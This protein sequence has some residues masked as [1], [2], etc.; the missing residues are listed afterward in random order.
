MPNTTTATWPTLTA[1]QV[2]RASDVEGKFDWSEHHLWPHSAGT[3]V[4]NAYDLGD[5]T[6]AY[7]RTAWLYSL[8]ATTSAQGIAIGTTTVANNSN[9]SFE[10][11][12]PRT[13]LIP[14]F[15]S[16][17]ESAFT[18]IN[19]MVGYNST[20]NKFRVYQNGGWVDMVGQPIGIVAMAQTST[21]DS[22]TSTVVSYTG[23]G[24]VRGIIL[25]QGVA[26]GN[27]GS[28]YVIVD[29]VT[30]TLHLPGTASAYG[31]TQTHDTTTGF[32]WTTAGAT[33][34]ALDLYFRTNFSV[35][36]HGPA[37]PAQTQTVFVIYERA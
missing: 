5:S 33:A 24:R 20:T 1:G 26:P 4:S 13:M 15:T 25:S 16:A 8:N 23:A 3:R 35:Q 34:T 31:L 9:V 6:T 29:S 28:V 14:R 10:V 22:V 11:A 32:V 2:A 36:F 12:G 18:G 21:T 27:T 30:S 7:W 19:G 17:Q 37:A